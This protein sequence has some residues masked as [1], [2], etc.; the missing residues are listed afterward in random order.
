MIGIATTF[1]W[2]FL[3]VFSVSAFYFIKDIHFNFGEPQVSL[4]SDNKL[5]FSLPITIANL[6]YYNIGFFNLT[7]EISDNEGFI[8]AQGST[9]LPVIKRGENATATHNMTIDVNDFL[10][11]HRNYLFDDT[12][13]IVYGMI[14]MRVAEAIPVQASTNFSVPWG[15]PLHN[16]ALGEI[17][18]AGYNGTHLRTIVP[19][20]F[21]NHAFFDLTGDIQMRMYNSADMLLGEGQSVIYAVQNS[22]YAG[23]VELYV[24]TAGITESGHFEINFLTPFFRS[25]PLVIPYG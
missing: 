20:N 17:E 4:T 6:G 16:F 9:F 14:G 23:Y 12:E 15:A 10:Q 19:I 18:Y 7:T 11:N 5:L 25:E 2:I 21:E 24:P 22:P 3:I 8:I 1:F 13:L